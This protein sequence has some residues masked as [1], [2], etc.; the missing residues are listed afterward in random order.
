MGYCQAD[1]FCAGWDVQSESGFGSNQ[2]G[3]GGYY[4][5]DEY[6]GVSFLGIHRLSRKNKCTVYIF[7]SI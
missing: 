5:V 6:D 1:Y 7:E 4:V 3:T 2:S